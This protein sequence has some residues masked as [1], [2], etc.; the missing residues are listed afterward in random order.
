MSMVIDPYRFAAASSGF[1]PV[2]LNLAAWYDAS[3][4]AS[5]TESGGAVSQ[6]NDLSG[7]GRHAVQ[8]TAGAK[9]GTG[10]ASQNGLNVLTFDGGD[11]L[12]YDAGSD[13]VDLSPV[14]IFIVGRIDSTGYP[15]MMSA[16]RS[17]SGTRDYQ[18]PN[19]CVMR[20]GDVGF[21]V[22]LI[23]NGGEPTSPPYTD[24]TMFIFYG[25]SSGTTVYSAVNDGTV[26]SAAASA[27]DNMRY[28]SLG[29]GMNQLDPVNFD[30]HMVGRL[31]EVVIA[32][33]DLSSGDID[34]MWSYLNDKWAVY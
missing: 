24:D 4:T 34:S 9:P 27:P 30:G 12:L 19:M 33:E 31:A 6:W 25:R 14:T 20:N 10:A 5:I 18:G 21:N 28:I 13:V 26:Y 7:N 3:D 8:S 29:A 32:N 23:S 11:G 16:R 22:R 2:D 15:R 1:S 17:S